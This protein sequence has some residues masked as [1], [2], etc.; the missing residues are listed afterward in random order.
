MLICFVWSK[1][2]SRKVATNKVILK[3]RQVTIGCI[4][5]I[6]FLNIYK[7]KILLNIDK[8]RLF[9]LIMLVVTSV[10]SLEFRGFPLVFVKSIYLNW[11]TEI[12]V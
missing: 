2:Q 9:K 10:M 11:T 7:Q 5:H 4:Q 8:Q 6:L 3:T 1:Y 12:N